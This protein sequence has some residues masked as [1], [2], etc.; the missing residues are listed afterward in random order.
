M[1]D[2]DPARSWVELEER[3]ARTES[4]RQRQLLQVVIDHVKAEIGR[5]V[6]G[7]MATLVAEPNY[8]FWVGG[9]DVG[10]KGYEGVRTYYEDF[11]ADGGAVLES[12]KER[13]VVDDDTISHENLNRNLV[14]G[15]IARRRGYTV[16]DESGHY[17][18]RFR[19]VIW[20]SFDDAGLAYGEDSYSTIDPDDWERVADDDLPAAYLDYLTEIGRLDVAA[21]P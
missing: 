6:D 11:V 9:R 4:P 20:W 16:P 1:L 21:A 17:L 14:S 12:I 10:P 19:T 5:D 3:L 2:F 8:H 13:I 18:V 7:L 15:R